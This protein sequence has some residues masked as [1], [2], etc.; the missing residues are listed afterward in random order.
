MS[1]EQVNILFTC[2]NHQISHARDLDVAY[3]DV[4]LNTAFGSLEIVIQMPI[5]GCAIEMYT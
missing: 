4:E 3:I 2:K 5:S 1:L